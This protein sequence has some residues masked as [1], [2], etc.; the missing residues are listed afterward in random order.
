MIEKWDKFFEAETKSDVELL[1]DH[2][3]NIKEVFCD[4]ED[5][6]LMNLY[7]FSCERNDGNPTEPR[8]VPNYFRG[9]QQIYNICD[10]AYRDYL[11][12]GHFHQIN[13][14][15]SVLV[16]FPCKGGVLSEKDIDLFD[17]ILEIKGRLVDMGYRLKLDLSTMWQMP[18][19]SGKP[20]GTHRIMKFKVYFN[21][22]RHS[23]ILLTS[24]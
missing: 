13:T 3:L 1:K 10:Q 6:G 19:N 22:F 12:I 15:L 11:K 2:F 18:E 14:F 9:D 4:F 20:S 16:D 17:N 24:H 7:S 5:M 23:S 21:F 8:Q